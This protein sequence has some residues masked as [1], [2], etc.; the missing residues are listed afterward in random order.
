MLAAA[1][2]S[3]LIVTI[4][5]RMSARVTLYTKSGCHLCERVEKTLLSAQR[6]EDFELSKV[7]ILSD[8]KL[9]LSYGFDIPVVMIGDSVFSTHALNEA[10]FRK[11]IKEVNATHA[12]SI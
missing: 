8:P 6:D 4:I 3:D 7:D 12:N 10:I 9:M 2:T 1:L 11:T 5:A